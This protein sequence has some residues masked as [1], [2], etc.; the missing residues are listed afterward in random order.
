MRYTL[1]PVAAKAECR[2]GAG[3]EGEAEPAVGAGIVFFIDGPECGEALAEQPA[4]RILTAGPIDVLDA[5][6]DGR[7]AC[8]GNVEEDGVNGGRA[9]GAFH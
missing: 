5:G 4:K 9:G 8:R 7:R 6:R 2:C 3:D 1:V